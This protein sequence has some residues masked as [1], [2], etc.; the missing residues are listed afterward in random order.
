MNK[1]FMM[2]AIELS[3]KNM[4]AGAGGPFGAVIV[5]D[6]KIIGE[7]WNQ[8]TSTN[9]PSAH[10]EV[11]AIRAACKNISATKWRCTIPR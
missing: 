4:Q 1:D 6:G 3:R 2:R 11:T 9:D 5:K 10:A 7:G 8:V